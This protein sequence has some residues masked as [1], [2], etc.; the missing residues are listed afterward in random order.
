M[1][2]GSGPY[3]DVTV[4]K[5]CISHFGKRLGT[6]L[7]KLKD[8]TK[9]EIVCTSG[10]IIKRSMIGGKHQLTDNQINAYQFYF[11]K[12]I[13]DTTNTSV[14]EMKK[15]VMFTFYHSISTDEEPRHRLCSPSWCFYQKALEKGES[16]PSHD[17][18]KNYLRLPKEY[19][20]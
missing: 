4:K 14:L 20:I 13:R 19:E 10:K 9:E 6:R 16:P 3:K 7:R 15:R 11:G 5:E 2:D 17:T 18:M 12:G 8:E 1:N